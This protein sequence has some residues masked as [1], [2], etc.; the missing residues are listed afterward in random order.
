MLHYCYSLT[1]VNKEVGSGKDSSNVN[2][3]GYFPVMMLLSHIDPNLIPIHRYSQK[4]I[5]R[6]VILT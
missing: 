6:I 5:K 4:K 3:S 2:A 1:P